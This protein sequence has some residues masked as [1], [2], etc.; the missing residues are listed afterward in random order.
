MKKNMNLSENFY[1][2]SLFTFDSFAC[3]CA[4]DTINVSPDEARNV[5]KVVSQKNKPVKFAFEPND[6]LVRVSLK[7][8]AVEERNILSS[9]LSINEDK[10]ENYKKFFEKNGFFFP[11]NIDKFEEIDDDSLLIIISRMK[12]TVELMS[13]ISEIQ[14][15]NYD[16]ILT[17]TLALL[18]SPETTIQIGPH[19][20]KT[21]KHKKL[22]D[23]L[24]ISASIN[25]DESKLKVDKDYNIKITDSIYG[26]YKLDLDSYRH[27]M[28][29]DDLLDNFWRK[30]VH[31]YVNHQDANEDARLIIE[32][33]FHTFVDIGWFWSVSFDNI[34]FAQEPKWDKFDDKL[35]KALLEVTKIVIAEEINSN[36]TGV[37]PEY[38]SVIMEPRWRV[39]SLMSALY[40]SIFYMKPNLELTRLCANPKCGRYFKVSRTSL[41]KKYC[42]PECANRANQNRYRAR[43]KE[44]SI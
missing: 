5:I 27:F 2:N 8:G 20:Y 12:A 29:D 3:F 31:S 11:I 18:L 38:D 21:C 10:I 4:V 9:L 39:E 34:N 35:K 43:K 17:L 44:I 16:R 40:F 14:R 36:I 28:Y 26:E 41:K 37:Y 23:E 7:S 6:G 1:Q 33:L 15:K 25:D 19:Q 13:Q 42:C 32:F 24:N 22:Y 30:I